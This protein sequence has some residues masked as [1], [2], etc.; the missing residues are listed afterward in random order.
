MNASCS[1]C[2]DLLSGSVSSTVCGHVF[3]DECLQNW[4]KEKKLCPQC[5]SS[6]NAPS[7]IKLYFTNSYPKKVP[8]TLEEFEKKYEI[9]K[10]QLED[11]Q[12]EQK[13]QEE[14]AFD[15][16]KR[17]KELRDKNKELDD[18]FARMAS[19]EKKMSLRISQLESSLKNKSDAL[20][21]KIAEHLRVKDDFKKF[22][23][24]TDLTIQGL[25]SGLL[26]KNLEVVNL[27]GSVETFTLEKIIQERK[28]DKEIFIKNL[29]LFNQNLKLENLT[30]ENQKSKKELMALKWKDIYN[31]NLHAKF[32]K[33]N[34]EILDIKEKL[35]S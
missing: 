8:T 14:K 21:K 34:F 23:Q 18:S 15:L 27:Q 29:A 19:N 30:R 10:K 5:R 2:L 6:V 7:L 4:L 25:E 3:H 24:D 35:N 11:A 33:L 31:D 13:I 20:L 22:K 28:L 9:M 26:V 16:E 12:R 1:I 32:D 17:E